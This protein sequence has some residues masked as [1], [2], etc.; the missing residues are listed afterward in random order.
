MNRVGQK[1]N[2]ERM[3]KGLSEKALAKKLGVSEGFIKEVEQGKRVVNEKIIERIS[4]ILG[5]NLNDLDLVEEIKMEDKAEKKNYVPSKKTRTKAEEPASIWTEAFN[6]ILKSIPVYNYNMNKI[7]D[8]K[9]MPLVSNKI[10]GY[11]PDKVFF[12]EINDNDMIGFR[13]AKGD[14]AFLYNTIQIN[15][16]GI[17][18]I[19]KEDKRLIRQVKR[20]EGNKLLLVYNNGTL[21]TETINAKDIKIIGKIIKNEILF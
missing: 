15:K 18:L 1:I 2:I 10:E 4:K 6:S 3:K 8:N 9:L 14:I 17:F 7:I 13:I 20:L 11:A 19:E 16:E 12:V 5:A 21:K